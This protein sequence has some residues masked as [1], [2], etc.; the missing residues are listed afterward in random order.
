MNYS[1]LADLIVLIHALFVAFVVLGQ[2]AILAGLIFRWRWIRNFPFRIVHLACIGIVVAQ[3]WLGMACPLTTLE[4]WFRELGGSEPYPAD[5]IGYWLGRL[6]FFQA[7][8]WV[9]VVAYSL[10][11]ALV[12]AT[13]FLAP[14]RRANRSE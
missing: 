5:F 8:A 14:P 11:G 1:I 9:F 2:L 12:V 13:F 4:N 10:F 7:P 6:I 3:S